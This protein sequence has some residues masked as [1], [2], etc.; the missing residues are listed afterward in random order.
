MVKP[1]KTSGLE[2]SSDETSGA[3]FSRML[4]FRVITGVN[5]SRMPNS[6]NTMET[7]LL[8]PPPCTAG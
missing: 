6:L 3:T 7:A 1:P 2:K 5:L 8:P 4:P